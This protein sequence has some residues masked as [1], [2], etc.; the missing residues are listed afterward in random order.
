MTQNISISSRP[1]ASQ[2]IT[3]FF[4]KWLKCCHLRWNQQTLDTNREVELTLPEGS[5]EPGFQPR[6][7]ESCPFLFKAGSTQTG[8]LGALHLYEHLRKCSVLQ[9]SGYGQN[10]SVLIAALKCPRHLTYKEFTGMFQ[11]ASRHK[12]TLIFPYSVYNRSR[13]SFPKQN[14]TLV[15][16]RCPALPPS[17]HIP[18][19]FICGVLTLV[20][21]R[22]H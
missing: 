3:D 21:V 16:V 11:S 7:T 18:C 22:N 1:L 17:S 2:L 15:T 4:H 13:L 20:S 5:S 10:W 14:G 6:H 9:S 19:R 8:S 12:P